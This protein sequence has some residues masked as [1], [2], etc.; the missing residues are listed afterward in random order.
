MLDVVLLIPMFSALGCASQL[1]MAQAGFA[2]HF[3]CPVLQQRATI[4]RQLRLNESDITAIDVA[5]CDYQ[6]EYYCEAM[7]TRMGGSEN[8]CNQRLKVA[9]LA[10]DGSVRQTYWDYEDRGAGGPKTREQTAI[11]SAAHDLS[12]PPESIKVVTGGEVVG[13]TYLVDACGQ[14]LTYSLALANAPLPPGRVQEISTIKFVLSNKMQ[15]P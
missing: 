10:T 4:M 2:E 7:A 1:E 15:I 9:Y 3:G 12:C 5:G 6:G 8:Y 14:R 13:D 11:A